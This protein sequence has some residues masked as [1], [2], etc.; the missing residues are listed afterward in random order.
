MPGCCGLWFELADGRRMMARTADCP[1]LFSEYLQSCVASDGP[2][3]QSMLR[4]NEEA[5]LKAVKEGMPE[6]V[7]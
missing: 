1:R 4:A 3:Q 5:V 7:H 2:S 6:L